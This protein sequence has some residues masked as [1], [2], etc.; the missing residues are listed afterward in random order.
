MKVSIIGLGKLGAPLAACLA[1]RGHP[2]TGVDSNPR[3]VQLINEGI[4]PVPETGLDDLILEVHDHLSATDDYAAAIAET[5]ATFIIVPTPSEESGGFSLRY[6]LEAVEA[7]GH[8]L[9]K[10]NEYHLIVLTSTVLPGA[11]EGQVLPALEA[12][13]G[14][15]CGP[16]FGLCYNPEF[17][18]LGSVIRDTLN[19]DIVLI[20][21]SDSRAGEML[22]QILCTL[23]DNDPQIFHTNFVN[24][25]LSKLAVNTFVTTKIS[26]ANM[27]ADICGRLPGADVDVVTSAI[28]M[29]SRIGHKYLKG[30]VGYGGPCFPRDN[31]AFSYL[32]RQV[33]AQP[34]LAEATDRLNRAQMP[35][36]AE[37]VR[38]YL[39]DG[40]QVGILGLSYK[41]DT[42]VAEESQ[43]IDLARYL[44]QQNVPVVVYDPH[45]NDNARSVLG[46][47]VQFAGSLT[48]CLS[49][50][51]VIVV[52]VPWPEF[53]GIAPDQLN[54]AHG[55]PVLIDCWRI[56]N[57]ADFEQT[58]TYVAI[59][60]QAPS[61]LVP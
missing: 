42:S 61:S 49:R 6:V 35:R 59:G 25:E 14:K 58:A 9:Q 11:T 39:P 44:R 51:D 28:G 27:L 29:D 37:L 45:A 10:K 23:H 30:A 34:I 12:A 41:P 33:G 57:P 3:V 22:E 50:V 2:V 26:Y 40:G 16:D 20:G 32:A 24:A 54:S 13:S 38:H 18:A 53:R 8:A 60:R 19:P 55:R 21:E 48:D 7:I 17:I 52:V 47:S 46:N 31:V 1:H 15:R 43:G 4:S 56:L 36:L 5:Q